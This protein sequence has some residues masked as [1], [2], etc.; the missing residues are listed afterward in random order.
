MRN[1][2][3]TEIEGGVISVTKLNEND[4]IIQVMSVINNNFEHLRLKDYSLR[5]LSLVLNQYLKQE[6]KN[7]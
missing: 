5:Q 1:S 2:K 3:A 4:N 6:D 7:G